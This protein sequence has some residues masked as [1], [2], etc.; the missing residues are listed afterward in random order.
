M[1]FRELD[2]HL[3]VFKNHLSKDLFK[4]Y[5]NYFVHLDK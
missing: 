4:A 3:S 1:D 2:K 5:T